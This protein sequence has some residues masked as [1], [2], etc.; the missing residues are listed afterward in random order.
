MKI[1]C[2]ALLIVGL[3]GALCVGCS[4]Q[5]TNTTKE[6]MIAPA[7]SAQ[8]KDLTINEI[9]KNIDNYLGK[10]VTLK[11]SYGDPR[12]ECAGIPYKRSDW[13]IYDDTSAIYVSGMEPGLERYGKRDWGKPLE[14]RGIVKRTKT[15]TPYISAIEVKVLGK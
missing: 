12:R 9:R 13:M 1:P 14:V 2:L 11:A 4:S 6:K 3:I 10:E 15:G 7:L 8:T 5:T